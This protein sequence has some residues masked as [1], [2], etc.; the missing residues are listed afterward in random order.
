MSRARAFTTLFAVST[1]AVLLAAGAA[2]AALDDLLGGPDTSE[3]PALEFRFLL[4]HQTVEPGTTALVAITTDIPE[5][6]HLQDQVH[7][8]LEELSLIHI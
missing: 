8:T 1:T 5:G 3:E 2:H 6:Y 4:S 7:V